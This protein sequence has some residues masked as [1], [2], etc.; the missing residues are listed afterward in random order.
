MIVISLF[1]VFIVDFYTYQIYH[2]STLV[3][4]LRQKISFPQ[5]EVQGNAFKGH[6]STFEG[7]FVTFVSIRFSYIQVQDTKQNDLKTI[8]T[9]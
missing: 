3:V 5:N 8:V 7:Y 2:F 1:H 9:F 6:S 4:L